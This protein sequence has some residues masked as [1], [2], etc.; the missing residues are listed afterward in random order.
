MAGGE[1]KDVDGDAVIMRSLP[2]VLL[3]ASCGGQVI[4]VGTND[5]ATVSDAGDARTL[6]DAGEAGR[7][8]DSSAD[9]SLSCAPSC[10]DYCTP[11][12][13]LSPFAEPGHVNQIALDSTNVYWS[14]EGGDIKKMALD[15]HGTITTLATNP[16]AAIAI[17][18]DGA[19][20]YFSAWEPKAGRYGPQYSSIQKVPIEG[21]TPITLATHQ[22]LL[23][24]AVDSKSVY[25]TTYGEVKRVPLDGGSPTVIAYNQGHTLSIAV[26]ATSVYWM[27]GRDQIRKAPLDGDG[28]MPPKTL[29]SGKNASSSNLAIDSTSVYWAMSPDP[30][31]MADAHNE[32]SPSLMRVSLDG[33]TPATLASEK[34]GV[35]SIAV[36]STSV[37]WTVGGN[38]KKMPA[39]GGTVTTLAAGSWHHRQA[40]DIAVNATSLVWVNGFDWTL[41]E[42]TPK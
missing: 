24:I 3:V 28:E 2:V 22:E 13:C 35:T 41:F 34:D 11:T 15:G 8:G 20:V 37:Y 25:F 40:L 29:V 26:D 30:Q 1:P 33:G 36:D 4:K 14:T 16:G 32:S 18:V 17:A 38:V 31:A 27:N 6:A 23:N 5:A 19:Y 10:Y 7:P 12:A 42:L 39:G 21:G 9:T